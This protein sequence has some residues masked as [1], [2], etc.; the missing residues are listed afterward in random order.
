M[1][2]F[3]MT[4]FNDFDELIVMDILATSHADAMFTAR[5]FDVQ[6]IIVEEVEVFYMDN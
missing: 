5:L 6:D 2:K 4:A 1:I 3:Q